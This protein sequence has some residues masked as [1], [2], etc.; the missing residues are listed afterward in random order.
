M[1]EV[2]ISYIN[3]GIIRIIQ[4]IKLR[5][6]RIRLQG[7]MA[8]I[9]PIWAIDEYAIIFHVCICLQTS[10][11]A[12]HSALHGT[13]KLRMNILEIHEYFI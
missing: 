1:V 11:I 7:R 12:R 9:H 3:I 8:I 10:I 5:S 6:V 4:I 13:S 2:V